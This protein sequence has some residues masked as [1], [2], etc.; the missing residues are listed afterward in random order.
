MRLDSVGDVI[1]TRHLFIA[2][3][4]NRQIVVRMGRPQPWANPH[5]EDYFCPFQIVGLGNEAVKYAAGVDAFQAVELGLRMIGIELAVLNRDVDGQL[6]WEC[7]G[8][9]DLGFPVPEGF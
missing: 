4:P 2:N 3:E 6:R 7:D 1:A 5:G 8:H 9:G